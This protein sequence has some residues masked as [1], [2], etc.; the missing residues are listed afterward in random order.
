MVALEIQEF[1]EQDSDS[2]S[3]ITESSDSGIE[4]SVSRFELEMEET[5]G[6]FQPIC[7][8]MAWENFRMCNF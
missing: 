6:E 2:C 4:G 5:A 1:V 8:C 7:N 3:I